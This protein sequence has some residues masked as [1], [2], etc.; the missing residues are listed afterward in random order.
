MGYS[1]LGCYGGEI[2]TP[3]LNRLAAGG[4]RFT[5]FYNTA[6][7]CPTRAALLT[8]VYQHQAGIGHMTGNYGVPSYQGYLNDRTVTIAEALRPAGYAT[9]MTGKWHVG[10][11][12]EH[13]PLQRGFDRYWG[14]PSGGG[15]YFKD[16]LKVRTN[17]FFTDGNQRIEAP[18]DLYVTDTFTDHAL[19]FIDEAVAMDKPFFLYL[20]HIAPHWPLQAK[21]KDIEKYRGRYDVGWDVIREAR[22]RKQLELGIVDPAW[23]LS[24]R[25]PQAQPWKSL[26]EAKRED[27]AHRMSIYAAQV[28]CIDQNIGRLIERLKE[29]GVFDNTLILFLSDNGCSAEGG[30]GG[31]SRG[32]KG[33]PIGQAESYASLGLQWANVCDTPYRKFK[34]DTREGGIATPLIAHWPAGIERR[35]ALEPTPGHV[36]DLLPTCLDVAGATYPDER[37]GKQTIPPEGR[38]LKPALNGSP[39]ERDDAIYWEHQGNRA[40]R[41][42]DWKL[43]A[44]HK[45]P[46]ALYNLKRDR[47]EL[48]DPARQQPERVK[49]LSAKWDAWAARVGVQPW[50]VKR[51][52][53]K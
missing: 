31:F 51:S 30:P 44:P 34:M 25:D 14:T 22:Y 28:D 12:P 15:V 18:E 8:G 20:A 48:H 17:V 37:G 5:Q 29:R 42:G 13:W 2:E 39:V 32:K 49:Q 1:D 6:R 52:K 40:V 9:L 46:W 3:Q 16:T 41:V 45:Q 23:K 53:Q 38:S 21:P 26:D 27:L 10:S 50:P 35:G 19:R 4:V 11:Q 47:T 43:V 7:C 33:V 24:P 36:I